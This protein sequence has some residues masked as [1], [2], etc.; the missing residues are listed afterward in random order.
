MDGTILKYT[1]QIDDENIAALVWLAH[2]QIIAT[3]PHSIC[4][5]KYKVPFYTYIKDLCY[6]NRYKNH[7]YLSFLQ[8]QDMT[9]HPK[10]IKEGSKMVAKYFIRNEQDCIQNAFFEILLDAIALQDRRFRK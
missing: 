4:S 9:D 2:D 3:L 6:I 10:L 8:G 1:D 5:T 7:I